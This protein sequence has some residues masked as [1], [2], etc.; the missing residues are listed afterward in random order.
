MTKLQDLIAD[1]ISLKTMGFVVPAPD[2]SIAH[3]GSKGVMIETVNL[4]PDNDVINWITEQRGG[5]WVMAIW[6]ITTGKLEA[7]TEEV[8]PNPH[9]NSH[10]LWV[11]LVRRT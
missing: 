5:H 8:V 2:Y 4:L 6:K 9:K 10:G 7:F 3:E 1:R 11:Y